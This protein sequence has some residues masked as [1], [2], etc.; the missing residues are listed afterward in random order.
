MCWGVVGRSRSRQRQRLEV[1]AGVEKNA[2]HGSHRSGRAGG[3][4]SGLVRNLV[5]WS[6]CTCVVMLL[7]SM[8]V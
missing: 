4:G 2:A 8:G 6:T 7:A 5:L 1:L 3:A